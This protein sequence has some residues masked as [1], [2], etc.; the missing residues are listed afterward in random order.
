MF[1]QVRFMF[2]AAKYYSRAGILFVVSNR[3][4][5]PKFRGS[6]K[7]ES[8][9]AGY[10]LNTNSR[11]LKNQQEVEQ[12]TASVL[13]P[14]VLLSVPPQRVNC[15][16]NANINYRSPLITLNIRRSD[17]N[18]PPEAHSVRVVSCQYRYPSSTLPCPEG[19]VRLGSAL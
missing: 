5:S 12:S 6:I 4:R 2:N 17:P 19:L 7:R 16:L 9:I 18:R 1:H 13:P 8:L 10:K 3:R 15:R 14:S 11:V